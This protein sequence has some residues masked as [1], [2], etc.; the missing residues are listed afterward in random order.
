M[1]RYGIIYLHATVTATHSSTYKML[2]LMQV[3]KLYCTY[4]YI[5]LPEDE[6]LGLKHVDGII[7]IKNKILV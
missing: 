5:C 2:I 6:P 1:Y 3:N 4:M 7:K